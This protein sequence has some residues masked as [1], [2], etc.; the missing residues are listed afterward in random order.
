MATGFTHPE[1]IVETDWLAKHLDDPAVRVI[2]CT[3]HLVPPAAGGPYDVVAGRAD[4]EKAHIAGAAFIDIEHE[5][6]EPHE[7]LHFTMP[8]PQLFAQAMGRI[9]VGDDTMVVMYSTANHWWA[10]RLW[11]MLRVF[12][13]DRA[14][15]L[16]GGFQKWTREGRPTQSGPAR[17]APA[18]TFTPCYRDGHVVGKEA[19]RA[20]I[21][22]TDIC[23]LNALRPEQHDGSGG[24][25]YGRPGHIEG[26]INIA[27][28]NVVDANNEFKSAAVLREMFAPALKLPR[29]ITY[30]GGGIAATSA[31]LV[32]TML[33]HQNVQV[34][35]AS[36]TEW[37][38]D[39]SLP[40]ATGR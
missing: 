18:A 27:A 33:G 23:T 10:T 26:S 2:D 39:P 4:F 8:K 24:T 28:V 25:Q 3:T 21:G 35:D 38:Q 6:S 7:R 34:Y 32:L 17:A 31:T 22:R 5:I 37:A 11:W 14:A 36:L 13:H 16:N 30:C 29:V 40:M 9:G 15:V 1:F 19:V 12:G 20:A